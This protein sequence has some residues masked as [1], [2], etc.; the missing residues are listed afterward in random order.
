M[1]IQSKIDVL[2]FFA[3]IGGIEL[4]LEWAGSGGAPPGWPAAMRPPKSTFST[5]GQ[6][7]LEPY[8]I[9]VLGTR[10]PDAP[11]LGDLTKL[12]GSLPKADMWCGGFPCQDISSA[13][14]GAGITG[15]R[16]GLFFDWMKLAEIECPPMI[17]MENV[18]ALLFRGLDSVLAELVRIGYNAEW[19]CIP[20]AALGAKHRRDR[21]FI[22]ALSPDAPIKPGCWAGP[23]R[24]NL[25][26]DLLT[27]NSIGLWSE[28]PGM[29]RLVPKTKIIEHRLE[30]LGNAVVPQ[31][32]ELLGQMLLNPL[33]EP[34]TGIPFAELSDEG[35]VKKRTFIPDSF[36]DSWPRSGT[37]VGKVV[38]GRSPCLCPLVHNKLSISVPTPIGS[39]GPMPGGLGHKTVA[40][41]MA[42]NYSKSLTQVERIRQATKVYPTPRGM[43]GLMEI[44]WKTVEQ[45]EASM[46][47]RK[48]GPN[49]SSS[50][51][52]QEKLLPTPTGSDGPMGGGGFGRDTIAEVIESGRISSLTQ[53]ERCNNADID[54]KL[55]SSKDWRL[56]PEWVEW[57]MGFPRGW[58]EVETSTID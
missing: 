21:I 31:V 20:A 5:V 58:T 6:V 30:R 39:D 25:L 22:L 57:L 12:A 35:W 13:G 47:R 15:S 45:A 17:L 51:A 14:K 26:Y 36:T 19:E 7:E 37:L 38:S 4:G 18:G 16:S 54:G 49:L 11:R 41:A 33:A 55:P 3:G 46:K 9:S 32:A 1:A 43:D 52:L 29:T 56:N 10:W 53:N 23:K 34:Y 28:D 27:K 48:R 2:S 40:S 50:I 8:A 24:A 42:S 44:E